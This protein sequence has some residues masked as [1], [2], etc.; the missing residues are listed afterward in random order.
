MKYY[1]TDRNLSLKIGQNILDE[2]YSIALAS[3]PNETGGL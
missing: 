1:I 2:M 3:F